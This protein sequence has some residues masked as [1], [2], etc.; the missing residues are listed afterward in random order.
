MASVMCT[1]YVPCSAAS[2]VCLSR[3]ENIHGEVTDVC[4]A[5]AS[6]CEFLEDRTHQHAAVLISSFY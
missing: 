2:S 6:A 5:P 4:A 3:E 1:V